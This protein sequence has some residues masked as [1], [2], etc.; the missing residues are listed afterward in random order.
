MNGY[1]PER[2]GKRQEQGHPARRAWWWGLTPSTPAAAGGAVGCGCNGTCPVSVGPP[3]TL[4]QGWD[5]RAQFYSCRALGTGCIGQQLLWKVIS[6]G[7]DVGNYPAKWSVCW[8][9]RRTG[10]KELLWHQVLPSTRAANPVGY[11]FGKLIKLHLKTSLI[12][13]PREIFFSDIEAWEQGVSLHGFAQCPAEI[14]TG[15][16]GVSV[17]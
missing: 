9:W 15:P 4:L 8:V 1:F 14:L 17:Q 7:L 2:P 11:H 5:I 6:F 13:C 3:A 10:A 12:P 16:L